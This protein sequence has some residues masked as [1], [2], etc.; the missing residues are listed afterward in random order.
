M[1]LILIKWVLYWFYTGNKF[2]RGDYAHSKKCFIVWIY[3]ACFYL[4]GKHDFSSL[5]RVDPVIALDQDVTSQPQSAEIDR[6]FARIR[7]GVQ[8]RSVNRRK[9]LVHFEEGSTAS[10]LEERHAEDCQMG[11]VQWWLADPQRAR[12]QSA[13]ILD[14]SKNSKTKN[15]DRSLCSRHSSKINIS[16]SVWGRGI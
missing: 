12:Q 8:V 5:L 6:E 13:E 9:S 15:K 3:F 1:I 16:T 7:H 14:V 10:R 4:Q 2:L 11:Q